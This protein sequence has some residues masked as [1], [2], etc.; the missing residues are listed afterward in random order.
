MIKNTHIIE[1]KQNV[2]E[3]G[4]LI[5][6]EAMKDIPFDVKRIYYIYNVDPDQRR[7]FHAHEDLEQALICIHGKVKILTKTPFEEEIVTLDDP[8]KALYIGSMVWREMFD[9][10]NDAILLV[11]A[12]KLYN[13]DDYIR[14]YQQ[15]EEL[16]KQYYSKHI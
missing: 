10:E 3:Y 4:V 7:G 11:L 1:F 5:P 6:I 16:A 9:F 13:A 14:D 8:Q 2:D 15:F 12:S